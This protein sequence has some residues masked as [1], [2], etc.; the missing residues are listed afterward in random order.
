MGDAALCMAIL[1]A[2]LPGM[3][4]IYTGQESAFHERLEFFEKDTV[5]WKDYKLAS[6]YKSLLELKHSNRALWNGTPGGMMERIPTGN[7]STLFI[8]FREEMDD[9]V[10]ILTNLSDK[11]QQGV[12]QGKSFRGKY[13]EL[14]TSEERAFKRNESIQLKPWEF[15][16]Y[17]KK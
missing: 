6:F 2:T 8:F 17:I 13:T 4:L 3:P 14:F 12:L 9:K 15:L 10:F 16:V 11:K 5:D 1:T 7:D